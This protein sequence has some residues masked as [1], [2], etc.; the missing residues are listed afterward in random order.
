MK[1]LLILAL[2]FIPCLAFGAPYLICD[3]YPTT[4]TQPT[5]FELVMDGGTAIQSPVQVLTDNSVRLHYDLGSI[6][7]GTHNVT[8]AACDMWGCSSTVP[9]GFSKAVPGAPANTKLEK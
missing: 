7:A 1:W 2:V 9:F 6:S 4:V 8:V 3:P 5:Y